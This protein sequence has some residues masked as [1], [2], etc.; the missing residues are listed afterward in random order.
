MLNWLRRLLRQPDHAA[1]DPAAGLERERRLR[2]AT[3]DHDRMQDHVL[4]TDQHYVTRG[5]AGGGLLPP[6]GDWS[7]RDE[8]RR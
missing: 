4:E 8:P 7:A 6:R 2:E 3:R 5:G 1:P